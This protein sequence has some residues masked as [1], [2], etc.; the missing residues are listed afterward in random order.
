[1]EVAHIIPISGNGNRRY[2]HELNS[3]DNLLTLCANCHKRFDKGVISLDD[4]TAH[5]KS[6]L[7]NGETPN[8][9]AEDNPQQ[10]SQRCAAAETEWGDT[11][12][13]EATVRTVWKHAEVVSNPLARKGRNNLGIIE[14]ISKSTNT[15]AH[16]SGTTWS[17]SILDG[18]VKDNWDNSNGDLATDIFMGSYLRDVTDGFTQKSN[19]VVN[20]LGMTSIVRT[21]STYQTAFGTVNLHTHRYV[22]QSGD[23]TGR[24]L[25]I[26]PDKM[27]V[28][29]LERP[30]I[31]NEIARTGP[32]KKR[33]VNASMTLEVRNQDS[34]FFSTGF[35]IG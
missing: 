27:K 12:T 22:Q 9:T 1:M 24:V 19:T 30:Y 11:L 16:A 32:A 17:A 10:A 20:G 34:N 8:G 7:I 33:S 28:A 18:L 6:P 14:A 29:F 21:V 3:L 5:I 4:I 31:D 23:A 26:R 35:N 2:I 13:S 15:T 25:A